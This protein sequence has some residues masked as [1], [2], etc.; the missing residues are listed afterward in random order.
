MKHS[1]AVTELRSKLRGTREKIQLSQ[2]QVAQLAGVRPNDVARAENGGFA[3]PALI[4]KVATAV[5][6]YSSVTN[7]NE[8]DPTV[9]LSSDDRVKALE[10]RLGAL[11]AGLT[12]AASQLALF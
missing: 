5:A 2:S 8:P 12:R 6:A 9:A 4:A 11:E 10:R 1:R 3:S 7:G